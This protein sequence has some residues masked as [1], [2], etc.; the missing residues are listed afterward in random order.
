MKSFKLHIFIR[1][2]IT[3]FLVI[4]SNRLVAQ[5]FLT[6]QLEQVVYDQMSLTLTDCQSQ[7]V[8]RELFDRCAEK[9]T[10][11]ICRST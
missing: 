7:V 1:L 4:W 9:R 2:V 11:W 3:S 5:Y 10:H 8:D 6:K